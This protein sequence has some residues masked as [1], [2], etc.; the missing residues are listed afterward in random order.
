ML[1]FRKFSVNQEFT[2]GPKDQVFYCLELQRGD[3]TTTGLCGQLSTICKN[4]PEVQYLNRQLPVAVNS[5][6]LRSTASETVDRIID[7]QYPLSTS[8]TVQVLSTKGNVVD[9]YHIA[10]MQPRN[11]GISKNGFNHNE[12][13][14]GSDSY[15]C[16]TE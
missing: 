10:Y 7:P 9:G 14:S 8:H 2:I 4:A 6:Q 16:K 3:S 13:N 5:S 1:H 15:I 12:T 11:Q